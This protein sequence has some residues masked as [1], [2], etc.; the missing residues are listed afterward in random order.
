MRG[1]S[2]L[3]LPECAQ[4]DAESEQGDAVLGVERERLLQVLA[5]SSA[6]EGIFL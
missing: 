3:G 5:P 4:H 2:R 1:L 6:S